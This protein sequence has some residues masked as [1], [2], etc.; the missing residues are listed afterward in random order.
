MT[1][2]DAIY[3]Q[4]AIEQAKRAHIADEVPV[5]AVIVKSGEVLATGFNQVICHHDPSS[6]AEIE[7]IRLAGQSLSNY[8]LIDT[9]LYVTLEPCSMCVG[10]MI[11]ARIKRVVFGAYD[12]KTGAITSALRLLDS[13]IHNHRIEWSGGILEE[14]CVHLLQAFFKEK[15][16]KT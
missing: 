16:K 7:A 10:A 2:N 15:R 1:D 4:M 6:H 5:G 9:T 11:H 14:E 3:M 8:R 13:P 12:Q